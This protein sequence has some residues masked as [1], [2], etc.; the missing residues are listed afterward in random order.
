MSRPARKP[1]LK[2]MN[3]FLDPGVHAWLHAEAQ[4][5]TARGLRS[6][7]GDVIRDL[8]AQHTGPR[9]GPESA[10]AAPDRLAARRI[11]W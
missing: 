5:R 4:R 7:V 11:D 10:A 3:T 2:R 9:G 6:T 8:V 1:A